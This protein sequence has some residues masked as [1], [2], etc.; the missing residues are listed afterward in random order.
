MALDAQEQRVADAVAE[1]RDEIVA[2]LCDLVAHDTITHVAGAPP[3][4]ERALQEHIAGRLASRGAAIDLWEPAPEETAGTP[5]LDDVGIEF[6]GRPQLVARFGGAAG[7]RD[8]VLCGHLD[9]VDPA[10]RAEWTGDPFQARVVDG[11][12]IGRGACDM[13]GGVASMIVASEVLVDLGVGLAGDVLVAT[14]TEEESTGAGGLALARRIRADG[15]IVP[16]PSSLVAWT[17]CRG[18]LLP[19]ITVP[20]RAGHAGHPPEPWQQGG[21]VNAVEKAAI[22]LNALPEL[23]DRWS[24]HRHPLLASPGVVPTRVSGGQWIVSYPASCQLDLHVQFLPAQAGEDGY[25]AA[26]KAEIA[27]WLDA[28]AAT[29]PWLA[30]HPPQ[31]SW[32]AGP[33]PPAEVSPDHPLV[34]SLRGA[35]IDLGQPGEIGGLDNWHDGATLIVEAGIPAVCYGPGPAGESHAVDEAVSIDDLVSCAQG[36]AVAALRFCGVRDPR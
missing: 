30:A 22:I 35:A 34:T 1:R 21:A 19:S 12:V 29:D 14:V 17:A 20:G 9:V 2:L 23:R 24:R 15:A 31:L 28:V 11:R 25:G 36:I 5:L 10:P 7:G 16:E 13:K 3:R 27:D 4:Q 18:S 33:V 8:L 6:T 32:L 26:L